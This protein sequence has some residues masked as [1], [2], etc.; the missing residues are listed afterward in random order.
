MWLLGTH[1][2]LAW[3]EEK[4]SLPTEEEFLDEFYEPCG[5]VILAERW[6]INL[7]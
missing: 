5:F 4:T 1:T 7:K 6:P 3:G 2:A